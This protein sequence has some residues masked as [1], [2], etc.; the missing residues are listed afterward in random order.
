MIKTMMISPHRVRGKNNPK[1]ERILNYFEKSS[2]SSFSPAHPYFLFLIRARCAR[3]S[4]SSS[5]TRYKVS[6]LLLCRRVIKTLDIF[7]RIRLVLLS[8]FL[9][10]AAPAARYREAET[11]SFREEEEVKEEAASSSSVPVVLAETDPPVPRPNSR[12]LLGLRFRPLIA[13]PRALPKKKKKMNNNN[14]HP[15]VVV[16]VVVVRVVVAVS[17]ASSSLRDDDGDDDKND[18]D[19][20]TPRTR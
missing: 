18:D 3:S 4:S 11:K 12:T 13:F 6:L 20:S 8:L 14:N 7:S 19:F 17:S 1:N 10:P 16:V 5:T 15:V 2:F 9:L